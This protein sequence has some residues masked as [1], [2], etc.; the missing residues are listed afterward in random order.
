[1]GIFELYKYTVMRVSGQG[2]L[3]LMYTHPQIAHT[4][5]SPLVEGTL[6]LLY[7]ESH[8]AQNFICL[9][10]SYIYVRFSLVSIV[11]KL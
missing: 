2:L 11:R 5:L 10:A 4:S 7:K 6:N 1:M 8:N 3:L 9:L